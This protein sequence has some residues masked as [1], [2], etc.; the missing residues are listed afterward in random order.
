MEAAGGK[1]LARSIPVAV[2]EAGEFTRTVVIEWDSLET[3]QNAY[4]GDAYQ[5]ALKALDNGAIH[6]FRYQEA[7][8]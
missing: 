8:S 7:M 2:R 3:A 4:A 1:F 5:K 6:E